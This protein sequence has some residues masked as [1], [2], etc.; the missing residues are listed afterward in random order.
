[1][2]NLV[3]YN[4]PLVAQGNAVLYVP[5]PLSEA[6][7]NLMMTVLEAMKPGIV[8]EP[9]SPHSQASPQQSSET[10]PEA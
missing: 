7:W 1:V 4:L 8:T 10:E 3:P 6:S 9:E 5:A 2:P